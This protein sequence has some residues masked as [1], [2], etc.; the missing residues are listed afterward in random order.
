MKFRSTTGADIHISLTSG[1]TALIT[2]VPVELDKVFHKEAISR[3]ALP[4]G[5][6]P[7]GPAIKTGFDRKQ[8]IIDTLHSML[9]GGDE[10]DFKNDGTP[11]LRK[12]TAKVGFKVDREEVDAAWAEV[13]KAD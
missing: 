13:S 7:D 10:D 3:G 5:V 11:D 2:S 1:Q 4:E 12:V 6:E 9:D 8:A